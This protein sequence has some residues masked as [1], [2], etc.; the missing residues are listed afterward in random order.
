MTWRVT[1]FLL[2]CVAVVLM[3]AS[4][5][6]GCSGGGTAGEMRYSSSDGMAYCHRDEWVEM[7]EGLDCEMKVLDLASLTGDAQYDK[8]R[9]HCQWLAN[10][11][12][13]GKWENDPVETG[14]TRENRAQYHIVMAS[15][16]RNACPGKLIVTAGVAFAPSISPSETYMRCIR[17]ELLCCE[18]P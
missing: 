6:A 4:A 14:L 13:G 15:M 8:A 9:A 11:G 10:T 3:A 7:G 1:L 18:R 16:I 17:S 5:W 12:P 2:I